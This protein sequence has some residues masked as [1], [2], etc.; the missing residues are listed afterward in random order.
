MQVMVS[1]VESPLVSSRAAVTPTATVTLAFTAVVPLPTQHLTEQVTSTESMTP[2]QTVML[3]LTPTATV[4]LSA[5]AAATPAPTRQLLSLPTAAP[6]VEA[7]ASAPMPIGTAVIVAEQ[8]AAQ[9]ATNALTPAEAPA[10]LL[11][12][13][14]PTAIAAAPEIREA[15]QG[16]RSGEE[17]GVV[18]TLRESVAP[19][20]SLAEIVLGAAFV[21]LALATAVVMLRWQPR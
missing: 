2:E 16:D 12:G 8:D 1:A 15:E 17:Q 5:Y 11:S 19:W 7:P 18:G 4:A 10:A 20:F 9:D 14:E 13:P 6:T 3:V 21:L